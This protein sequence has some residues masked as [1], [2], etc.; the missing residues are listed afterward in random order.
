M[1][2][3]LQFLIMMKTNMQDDPRRVKVITRRG[4]KYPDRTL[5]HS[6]CNVSVMFS[7]TASGVLLLPPMV[8]Y[9]SEHLYDTW[10]QGGPP[11]CRYARSKCGWFDEMIFEEW[12]QT[13]ALQY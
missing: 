5:D 7:G 3:Q 6:K 8:C 12:F 11:G 9:K 13:V 2:H 4:I 10:Q 1:F